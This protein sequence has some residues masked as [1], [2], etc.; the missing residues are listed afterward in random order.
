LRTIAAVS[1]LALAGSPCIAK[2]KHC[3]LDK[4][5][6]SCLR[7]ISD[8]IG[9]VRNGDAAGL[10]EVT[11]GWPGP[12]IKGSA[13]QDFV[14]AV[15]G[16]NLKSLSQSAQDFISATWSCNG[17]IFVPDSKLQ[18]ACNKTVCDKVIFSGLKP[19]D[20]GFDVSFEPYGEERIVPTILVPAK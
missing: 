17:Q 15:S 13:P 12:P 20:G 8:L 9:R 1:L 18:W 19:K 6:S 11:R 14:N 2:D 5:L 4:T 7:D 16:C 10:H 3:D